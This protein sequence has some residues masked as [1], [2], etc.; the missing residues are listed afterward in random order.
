MT[1]VYVIMII[2]ASL[3][4][5]GL[6]PV[7]VIADIAYKSDNRAYAKILCFK[8]TL[9]PSEE[10]KKA[11][12]TAESDY[13]TEEKDRGTLDTFKLVKRCYGAAKENIKELINYIFAEAIVIRE[14][15]ISGI[16]GTGNPMYTGMVYGAVSAAVYGFIGLAELP[17]KAPSSRA[18]SAS[19]PFSET[20]VTAASVISSLVNRGFG[21]MVIPPSAIKN[22]CCAT[23]V[24]LYIK[25]RD[26]S[27]LFIIST[28]KDDRSSICNC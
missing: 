10:V 8:F 11:A 17:R 16:I 26:L 23:F 5:I 9:Y 3:A 15:N 13:E 24:L 20:S 1:A 18:V 7:N 14:L 25:N 21:G 2:A 19:I 4:L 12:D 27:I 22:I 28:C 6:I